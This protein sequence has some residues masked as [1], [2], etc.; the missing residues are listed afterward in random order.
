MQKPRDPW[1][2]SSAPSETFNPNHPAPNFTQTDVE[3][4]MGP[5]DEA[6][7]KEHNDAVAKIAEEQANDARRRKDA[8]GS[9][10]Y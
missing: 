5:V 10:R 9:P 1:H 3:A 6:F 2:P 8:G 4:F 7:I